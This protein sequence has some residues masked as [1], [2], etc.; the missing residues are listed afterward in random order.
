MKRK[1]GKMFLIFSKVSVVNFLCITVSMLILAA[2]LSIAS[3]KDD[4][5]I[6]AMTRNL[7]LGADIFK[8]VEAALGPPDPDK[9]GLDVPWAVDEVYQTMLYT[10]FEARAEAIADEIAAAKPQVI[11]LQEVSTFYIQTPG[12][13]LIGNPVQADTVVIDFY[14]V[15]NDALEAR[16]MYY[17][18][19]SVTNADVELPMLTDLQFVPDPPYVIPSFDDVRMVDHDYVLVRKGHAASVADVGNYGFNLG[20]YLGD[21]YVEFTRGFVIVDV[22]VKGESYRFASTHL[23][24]RSAPES[25]YRVVQ[26]AQ[27]YQLLD[28]LDDLSTIDP[29]PV[30]L[31]GDLNSSSDDVPFFD[32]VYE[33]I[34]PPYMQAVYAGYLDTWLLQSKY[35]EGYTSGFEEEINLP[36][37]ALETRIDHIFLAPYDLALDKVSSDVVGDDPSEM[38][39]NDNDPDPEALLW[40]SDHAGVVAKIKFLAP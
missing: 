29:K 2:P 25:I 7:Y 5:K 4:T 1:P 31:V 3:A 11:G 35:D 17:D 30:I 23:E 12:D 27:M 36:E 6:N 16:G 26:A 40:P 13:F 34:V 28:T 33:L 8:V 19:F 22:D 21:V 24:V 15:L 37:D 10:N 9:Y 32:P 38:V 20:L 18:A 14:E 39:L